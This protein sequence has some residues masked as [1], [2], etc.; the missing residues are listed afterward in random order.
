M[1]TGFNSA[2][3]LIPPLDLS[4]FDHLRFDWRGDPDAA[5]SLEVALVNPGTGQDNIFGRGYHHP[6]HHA[7]W[8]Q[9][10]VPFTFLQPWTNGTT[11]DSSRVSGFFIS[12]VKDP[13]DDVGGAGSIALDNLNAYNVGARTIPPNFESVSGHIT[14][15]E[16]IAGWLADQQQATGLLKSWAEEPLCNA[17]TYDQA[18]ALIVFAKKGMW[19]EADALIDAL[20]AT[21]NGDGSWFKSR[22][23]ENL[24]AI[25]NNKWEGDIAWAIYALNRYLDLGGNASPSPNS[26]R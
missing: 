13:V 17:H 4:A 3:I 26:R 24:T 6:T 11:F 2:A 21:Q 18:L 15:S 7:W 19:A 8:G 22:N 14:A 20:V 23:C 10:V 1:A 9:L 16:S 25:N 12:V 5:N